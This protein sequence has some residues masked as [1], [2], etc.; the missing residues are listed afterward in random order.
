M[1]LHMLYVAVHVFLP[2]SVYHAL[3]LL[4]L[5]GVFATTIRFGC[6]HRPHMD[7]MMAAYDLVSLLCVDPWCVYLGWTGYMV[8]GTD[9]E[10]MLLLALWRFQLGRQAVSFLME[11]VYQKFD[12]KMVFHHTMFIAAIMAAPHAHAA[13]MLTA[14]DVFFF[15]GLSE[16]S[17]MALSAKELINLFFTKPYAP[18]VEMLYQTV[19]YTFLVLF[20]AIRIVWWNY[21]AVGLLQRWWPLSAYASCNFTLVTLIGLSGLQLYWGG[22]VVRVVLRTWWRPAAVKRL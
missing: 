13:G 5:T 11:F 16:A 9:R 17:T 18:V 10:A 7:V 22:L 12:V 1:L 6:T 3:A 2:W 14:R 4:L 15:G 8:A 20:L 21:H 19:R